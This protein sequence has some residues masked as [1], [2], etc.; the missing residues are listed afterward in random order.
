MFLPIR[1]F[2]DLGQS[3]PLGPPRSVPGSLCPCSRRTACWLPWRG[4][5]R[6]AFLPALASFFGEALVA[7]KDKNTLLPSL[8]RDW[9]W[10]LTVADSL[11]TFVKGSTRYSALSRAMRQARRMLLHPKAGRTAIEFFGQ[12]L[13]L[14]IRPRCKVI[15][16]DSAR[17][18]DG[19]F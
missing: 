12:W 19:R 4:R 14:L 11:L 15:P 1:S 10:Y 6:R 7:K 13:G 5:A 9:P 16:A 18:L 17:F 8:P 2:H 3:R